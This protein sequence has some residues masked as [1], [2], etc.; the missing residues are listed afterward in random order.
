MQS[1]KIQIQESHIDTFGHVNNAVYLQLFEDARWELVSRH[2]YDLNYIKK[3][4]QGPVVL[5]AHLKYVREVQLLEK[6]VITTKLLN[7]RKKIGELEQTLFKENG[8]IGCEANFVFGLFD[9]RDR[10]LINPTLEWMN[11]IDSER[12]FHEKII[13]TKP[14]S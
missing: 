11:A 6:V 9:M 8:T 13:S 3:T 5:E 10:K 2:G 4:Q 14:S 12:L 7:Y 1:F